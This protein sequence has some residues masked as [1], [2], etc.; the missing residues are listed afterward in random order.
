MHFA[1]PGKSHLDNPFWYIGHV[2]P[3][4]RCSTA[5]RHRL[6][7]GHTFD[8]VGMFGITIQPGSWLLTNLPVYYLVLLRRYTGK[9]SDRS[10]RQET[11]G[12]A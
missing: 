3:F 9:Y 6:K 12:K 5:P 11:F 2:A 1:L 8:K 4:G 10:E 7:P